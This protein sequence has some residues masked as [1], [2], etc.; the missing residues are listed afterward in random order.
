M[1][2]GAGTASPWPC[3]AA[4]TSHGSPIGGGDAARLGKD[5]RAEPASQGG[6]GV[7]SRLGAQA[8]GNR[9]G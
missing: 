7:S 5:A 1:A 3:A 8:A 2:G 6:D 4:H 9:L